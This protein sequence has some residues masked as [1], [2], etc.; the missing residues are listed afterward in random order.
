MPIGGFVVN[1]LPERIETVRKA[2]A[3]YPEV[4]IYGH[5]EQG[6]LIVVLDTRTSEEM[7][8]LVQEISRQE[9]VLSMDLAYLHGEDEV[10]KIEA[11]EYKPKIRFARHR[12]ES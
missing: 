8:A 5:D 11:G 7:E 3:V 1:V 9:G 12:P 4:E 10:E 2:L 6:R